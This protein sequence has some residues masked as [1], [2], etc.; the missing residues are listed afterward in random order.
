MLKNINEFGKTLTK[1]QQQ[2]INGGD[3]RFIP[4]TVCGGDGSFIYED[5]VKVCCY[6]PD[7]FFGGT[8]IC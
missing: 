8:Y 5:G 7:R 1:S 6:V 4:I 2:E 3:D